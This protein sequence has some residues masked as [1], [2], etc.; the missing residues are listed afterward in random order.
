[1]RTRKVLQASV[2]EL[3]IYEVVGGRHKY[4]AVPIRP[5]FPSLP[6]LRLYARTQLKVMNE[7]GYNYQG[8]VEEWH[9]KHA[10]RVGSKGFTWLDVRVTFDQGLKSEG[11]L[12]GELVKIRRPKPKRKIKKK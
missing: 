1:M 5:L 12:P 11:H 9:E 7:I 2:Y 4:V 3:T 10:L 6:D 8:A